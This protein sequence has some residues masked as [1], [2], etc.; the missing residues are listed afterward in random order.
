MF[1]VIHMHMHTLLVLHMCTH[2]HM[3]H[4]THMHACTSHVQVS[5]FIW[6]FKL[7]ACI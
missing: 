2:M 6:L 5:I 1:T 7:R 4:H 3:L